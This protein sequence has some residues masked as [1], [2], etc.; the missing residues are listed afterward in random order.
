[1]WN[2]REK[3]QGIDKGGHYTRPPPR[4]IIQVNYF[5]HYYYLSF[6]YICIEVVGKYNTILLLLKKFEKFSL[7]LHIYTEYIYI[8]H[9]GLG[10]IW[11]RTKPTLSFAASTGPTLS[12]AT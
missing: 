11:I 12:H 7:F 10:L 1:M 2:S 5:A 4:I 3:T 8:Y 9:S 6:Q